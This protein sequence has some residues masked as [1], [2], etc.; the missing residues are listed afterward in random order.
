MIVFTAIRIES[1]F[2]IGTAISGSHIIVD[3]QLS[4]TNPAKNC[5]YAPFIPGPC[6][7][8]MSSSFFMTLITRIIFLTAFELYSNNVKPGMVM[9]TTGFTINKLSIYFDLIHFAA[10]VRNDLRK[11]KFL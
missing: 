4:F 6:L 3:R 2:A 8:G 9:F 10:K 1:D 7:C 11:K 5:F